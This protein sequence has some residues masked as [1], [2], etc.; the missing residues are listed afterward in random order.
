MFIIILT[1]WTILYKVGIHLITISLIL[2][3][4]LSYINISI[5]KS[6]IYIS[7]L[8]VLTAIFL[9]YIIFYI[10]NNKEVMGE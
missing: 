2:G 6:L 4:Y 3:L 8:Y 10:S 1:T 7:T 5:I 9:I